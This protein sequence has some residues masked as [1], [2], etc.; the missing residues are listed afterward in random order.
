MEEIWKPV[1]GYEGLYQVSNLGRIKNVKQQNI[2]LGDMHV[3]GYRRVCFSVNCV[4]SVL[5]VHR[6]VAQTFIPNKD[7][8][9]CVN[10]KDCNKT[11]NEV[12]NLEWVTYRENNLHTINQGRRSK[13]RKRKVNI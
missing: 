6:I 10:H 4:S 3:K 2:L 12:E 11:N 5:L 1:I 8:K 7:N 9:P 13:T